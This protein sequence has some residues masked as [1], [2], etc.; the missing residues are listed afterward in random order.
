M[1]GT[2]EF[3]ITIQLAPEDPSLCMVNLKYIIMHSGRAGHVSNSS[4]TCPAKG[5]LPMELIRDALMV[6]CNW[7]NNY[8][9]KE[10]ALNE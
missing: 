2:H 6:S 4:W 10:M 3:R 9:G 8:V 1:T 7:L 5:G